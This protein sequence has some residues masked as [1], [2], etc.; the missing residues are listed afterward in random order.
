[1]SLKPCIPEFVYNYTHFDNENIVKTFLEDFA[2]EIKIEKKTVTARSQMHPSK[3][4][5]ISNIFTDIPS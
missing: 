4:L 3:L 1:M 2:G 5:I